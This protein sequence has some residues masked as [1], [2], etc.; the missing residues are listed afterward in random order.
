MVASV[1]SGLV[2]LFSHHRNEDWVTEDDGDGALV[3]VSVFEIVM[4]VEG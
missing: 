1:S 2:G 3:M 4:V